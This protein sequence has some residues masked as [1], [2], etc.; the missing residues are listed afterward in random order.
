MGN[1]LG[2]GG[3]TPIHYTQQI[4]FSICKTP[5]HSAIQKNIKATEMHPNKTN[6]FFLL[7]VVQLNLGDYTDKY[8]F[9]NTS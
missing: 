4:C 6:M 9:L 1:T 3:V 7:N 8:N 2:K 5:K